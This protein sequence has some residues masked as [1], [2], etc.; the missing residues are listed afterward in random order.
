M[1]GR[2]LFFKANTGPSGHGMPFAAGEALALKLAGAARSR[3]SPS[4]A[5]AG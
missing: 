4:R 2:T 1:A 3:S 5:R